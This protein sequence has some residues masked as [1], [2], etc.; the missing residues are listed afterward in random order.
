MS[1]TRDKIKYADLTGSAQELA[2][3]RKARHI[4][5]HHDVLNGVLEADLVSMILG[6]I[7]QEHSRVTARLRNPDDA[8]VEVVARA[9]GGAATLLDYKPRI[10]AALRAIA[11]VLDA[12][13]KENK[14][15]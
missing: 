8:M 14:D 7:D 13:T 15:G 2:L 12:E 6:E 5:K 3:R 4:L 1:N 9:L 11:D 10:K